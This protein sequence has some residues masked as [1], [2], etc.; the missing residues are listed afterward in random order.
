MAEV[1]AKPLRAA[2]VRL[3]TVMTSLSA[4]QRDGEASS[5]VYIRTMNGA[6]EV[7][8]AAVV[9][10]P[11]GWLKRHKSSITPL[12][13]RIVQAVEALTYGNLEKV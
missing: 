13:D 3:E 7:F 4:A 2:D 12:T 1:A 5:K 10:T 6:E 11:L 8:D 9:T